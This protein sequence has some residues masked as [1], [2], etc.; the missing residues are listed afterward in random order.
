MA[1]KKLIIFRTESKW[2]TLFACI[3]TGII[4]Y[5]ATNIGQ[6]ISKIVNPDIKRTEINTVGEISSIDIDEVMGSKDDSKLSDE[7]ALSLGKELYNKVQ[8]LYYFNSPEETNLCR[9]DTEE[10][11]DCTGLYLEL[12]NYF[13]IN[14][15]VGDSNIFNHFEEKDG[16]YYIRTSS[17]KYAG[18]NI[19]TL[20]LKSNEINKITF[21]ATTITKWSDDSSY[22]QKE[23]TSITEIEIIKE[24]NDKKVSKY[25]FKFN[26]KLVE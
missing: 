23:E 3:M 12:K 14:N 22:N 13:S 16:K 18:S 6:M 7:E 11:Y 21:E 2:F 8:E 15:I 24:D 17:T 9:K 4:V 10:L 20:T 26:N 25:S 5:L 19:T 1:K